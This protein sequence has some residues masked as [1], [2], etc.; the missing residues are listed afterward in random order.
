M[1]IDGVGEI[2]AQDIHAWFHET[3]NQQLLEAFREVGLWPTSA[4]APNQ[5]AGWAKFR[6]HRDAANTFQGT[7]RGSDQREWR[8]SYRLGQ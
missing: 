8:K 4:P 7:G 1:N 3:D 5:G 2:V 6:H